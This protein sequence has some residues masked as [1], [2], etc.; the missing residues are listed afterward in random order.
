MPFPYRS[1]DRSGPKE[2]DVAGAQELDRVMEFGGDQVEVS[3][4]GV[5]IGEHEDR[6]PSTASFS[7]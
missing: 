1:P 7:T 4:E 2:L 6:G 3:V 5:R